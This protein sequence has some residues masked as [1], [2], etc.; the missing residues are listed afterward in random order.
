MRLIGTID[1]RIHA[2]RFVASLTVKEI[3]AQVEQAESDWQVWVKDEDSV[4]TACEELEVFL[5]N[6]DAPEY[7]RAIEQASEIIR[8]RQRERE[9]ARRQI[10]QVQSHWR[11]PGLITRPTPLTYTL[12]VISVVVSLLTS[13]GYQPNSAIFRALAIVSLTDDQARQLSENPSPEDPAIRTSAIPTWEWWRLFTP[14]FIHFGAIHLLFNSMVIFYF[15]R[16]IE[17]RNGTAWLALL[18][19]IIGVAANLVGLIVPVEWDGITI[20]RLGN[21][22]IGLVGGLSGVAYGL[23]GYIW[24]KI[25]F[26]RSA[27]FYL[28]SFTIFILVGWLILGIFAGDQLLGSDAKINNWA[29]GVGLVLG[30]AFGYFPKLKADLGLGSKHS[31]K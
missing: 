30:M 13:F 8:R 14:V 19:I 20:P 5:E 12:I 27:G 24:M 6:P 10:K 15:G 22:W 7:T 2:E 18:V 16:Q 4:E 28:T 26:D 17:D 9:A 29:H 21:H 1:N 11:N 23:F 3:P 25:T 31:N